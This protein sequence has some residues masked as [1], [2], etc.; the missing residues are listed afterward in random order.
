MNGKSL[1]PT[2]TADGRISTA[3]FLDRIMC[4]F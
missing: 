3:L 4:G 1:V 2:E